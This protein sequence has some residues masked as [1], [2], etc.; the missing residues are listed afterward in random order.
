MHLNTPIKNWN[1]VPVLG[2]AAYSG[3]GKTTLLT[4]LIP[5]L[6]DNGINIAMIKHAH[7]KFNMD[8]PGKDSY[9]L[10][11]AGAKQMLVASSNRYALMVE[12]D[13]G[14][15]PVFAEMLKLIDIR[16]ADII[17]VEGFRHEAIPKIEL[18]RPS[19]GKPLIFPKDKNVIAIASDEHDLIDTDLYRLP[20][21][22]PAAI[23]DFINEYILKRE[24]A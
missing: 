11:K 24:F 7:H 14:D 8:I 12:H 10:R 5:I 3:T 15:D 19:L 21:N 20:L 9:R 1:G 17:L 22:E 4:K 16:M 23:A 2:F 6:K 18:H 13:F